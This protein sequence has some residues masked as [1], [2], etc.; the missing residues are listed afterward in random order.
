MRQSVAGAVA[1]PPDQVW[2][3]EGD[4]GQIVFLQRRTPTRS[5][6][7]L[8]PGNEPILVLVDE[9][10]GYA[11]RVDE[12]D[13]RRARFIFVEMIAG[14][15][16][17]LQASRAPGPGPD[18]GAGVRR[19]H[20]WSGWRWWGMAAA[21]TPVAAFVGAQHLGDG[22]LRPAIGASR[23]PAPRL[24]S[25]R[26]GVPRSSCGGWG[27]PTA[28]RIPCGWRATSSAS[29]SVRLAPLPAASRCT[30]SGAAEH[31]VPG[32]RAVGGV[33]AGG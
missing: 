19:G 20:A 27:G 33:A 7:R 21:G 25:S 10:P 11:V 22:G 5:C 13:S 28:R 9:L 30:R 8:Y 23:R 3:T 32:G 14:V 26:G 18:P 16:I 6:F 15:L 1:V 12:D 17:N 24:P 29:A 4:G 2:I 31:E